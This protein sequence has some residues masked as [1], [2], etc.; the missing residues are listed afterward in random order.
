M[1]HRDFSGDAAEIRAARTFAAEAAGVGPEQAE[2]VALMASELAS[3]AVRHARSPFRVTV[4][5]RAGRLRIEVADRGDGVPEMRAPRP[6]EAT[7]RGLRIV[8][9]LSDA[10]GVTPLDDGGKSVWFELVAADTPLAAEGAARTPPPADASDP[11]PTGRQRPTSG[12]RAAGPGHGTA[13]ARRRRRR[14]HRA[15]PALRIVASLT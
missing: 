15:H 4:C 5:R 6:S 9:A 7:G 8:D 3:N 14:S 1:T 10:W 13:L 11:T 12:T 2:I